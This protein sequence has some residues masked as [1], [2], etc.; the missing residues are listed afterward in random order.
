M[1]SEWNLWPAERTE[2]CRRPVPR[3]TPSARF[4]IGLRETRVRRE[5]RRD[6]LLMLLAVSRALLTLLGADS[7]RSGL[8]AYLKVN[9]VKHRTHS[10]FRQGYRLVRM[11]SHHAG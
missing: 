3:F 8:D 11:P 7:E 10:L 9:T 4:G 5:A 2:P 6:R 1:R